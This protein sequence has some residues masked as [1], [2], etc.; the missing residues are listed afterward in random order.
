MIWIYFSSESVGRGDLVGRKPCGKI[1]QRPLTKVHLSVIVL[2]VR[3]WKLLGLLE[4]KLRLVWGTKKKDWLRISLVRG[5]LLLCFII[6]FIKCNQA[7]IKYPKN[8]TVIFVQ[9]FRVWVCLNKTNPWFEF[10]IRFNWQGTRSF[11][12]TLRSYTSLS[13]IY[14]SN[15]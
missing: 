10:S 2:D 7:I 3:M 1:L 6:I 15:F 13:G 14:L 5:N 8:I 4:L 12:R 9:I 11:Q